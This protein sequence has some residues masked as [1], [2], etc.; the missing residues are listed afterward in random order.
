MASSG[1]L[2]LL[3]KLTTSSKSLAN[4]RTYT[5]YDGSGDLFKFGVSDANLL[6]YNQS[7]KLAGPGSYGKYSSIMPKKTAHIMEKYLRSLHYNSTG[8]WTIPGM[9]VPYPID[10]NTGLSIKRPINP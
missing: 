8:Q 9:K 2:G 4:S 3:T 7:L 1:G 6:R 5:I 10:F